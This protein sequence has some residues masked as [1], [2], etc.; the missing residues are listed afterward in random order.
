[1]ALDP[2]WLKSHIR[3]IPGFPSPGILFKDITP[4][5]GDVD[6]VPGHGRR[7]CRRV[8]GP[9]GRPGRSASRPA[10]SSWVRRWPTSSERPSSR[11]ASRASCHGSTRRVEYALEYGTDR[12][13]IHVDALGAGQRVLIIDDVLATG[14]TAAATVGLVEGRGA[15]VVGL[16]FLVELDFL[17]GRAGSA[18]GGSNRSWCTMTDGAGR[19]LVSRVLPWRAAQRRRGGRDRGRSSPPI[20]SATRRPRP[21]S[22]PGP[23]RRRR[24]RTPMGSAAS[25]VTPTSPIPSPWPRSS[26]TSASTRT[27]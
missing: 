18:I 26:P 10:A 8:R 16:G 17:D 25:R 13:E 6:G 4:L 14:G 27:R 23:T 3:D 12:L 1:M 20:T 21:T 19:R 22:S 7:T 9:P 2:A 11:C 24:T 5:L 15:V